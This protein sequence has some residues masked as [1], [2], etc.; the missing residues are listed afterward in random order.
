MSVV[1]VKKIL[2]DGEFCRKCK[3]VQGKLESDTLASMSERRL[4]RYETTSS[5]GATLAKDFDVAT[6]PFFVVRDDEQGEWK[7]VRSYLQLKKMLLKASASVQE[8]PQPP[9]I[10]ELQ[11]EIAALTSQ[12]DQ[13]QK[14]VEDTTAYFVSWLCG[15]IRLVATLSGNVVDGGKDRVSRYFGGY[16]GRAKVNNANVPLFLE[17]NTSYVLCKSKC[18]RKVFFQLFG[19]VICLLSASAI[20]AKRLHRRKWMPHF[21]LKLCLGTRFVFRVMT[22]GQLEPSA[23]GGITMRPSTQRSSS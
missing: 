9:S 10:E 8:A 22:R 20:K 19:S 14:K 5:D 18:S 15:H 4:Q 2:E 11:A 3:D 17:T 23:A 13:A 21:Y 12:L 6:A 7:L 16:P 1:M